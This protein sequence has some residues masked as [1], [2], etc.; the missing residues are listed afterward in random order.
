MQQPKFTRILPPEFYLRPTIDVARALLGC[1]MVRRWR[2]KILAGRIVETEAYLGPT[3]RAAHVFGGRRTAR[4]RSMYLNGGHC[5][6]YFV[7]GLHYCVNVVTQEA[8]TPQAVLIRALEIEN[9]DSRTGAGPAKLCGALHLDRSLDGHLLSESPLWLEAPDQPVRDQE[10]LI[11]PRIGVD[12]A[13]EASHWPLRFG[14]EGSPALSKK[15]PTI[16]QVEGSRKLK[17]S[18][19]SV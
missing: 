10:I 18:L 1:F 19:R 17:A 7:Y 3:D 8:G 11:G 16:A 13:G 12:Y 5:Y 15:F 2:G 6:I 4:V 9:T 14:I